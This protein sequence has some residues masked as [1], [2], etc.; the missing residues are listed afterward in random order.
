MA[1]PYGLRPA[2]LITT[3]LPYLLPEMSMCRSPIFAVW[4][5]A[6]LSTSCG[7]ST[8]TA[9]HEIVHVRYL[10]GPTRYCLRG[11][12]PW[13]TG[14]LPP[15]PAKVDDGDAVYTARLLDELDAYRKWGNY[16]VAWCVKPVD[17]DPDDTPLRSFRPPEPDECGENGRT[18]T[19][20]CFDVQ[21]TTTVHVGYGVMVPYAQPGQP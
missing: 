18:V 9:D 12:A 8:K 6:S 1:L 2:R 21:P 17:L 20:E 10:Q 4:V 5:V 15:L 11:T 13:P 3:S 7:S 16:V 14:D 19:G